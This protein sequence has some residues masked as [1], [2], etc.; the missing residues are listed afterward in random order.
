VSKSNEFFSFGA[1]ETALVTGGT[2]GIGKAVVDLLRGQGVRVTALYLDPVVGGEEDKGLRLM[3]CDIRDEAA[4]VAVVKEL[5]ASWGHIDMLVNNAA[6]L[7]RAIHAPFLEHTTELFRNVVE[8]NLIGTFVML[9]EVARAMIDAGT[10]GRIVNVSSARGHLGAE[11]AAGY[12]S[13]KT[14][15]IGLTRSAALALAPHNIRVNAVAPGYI[16]SELAQRESHL[17]PDERF[18]KAI[19]LGRTGSPLDAARVIAA[20]LSAD[21]SFVTGSTWDVDGGIRAY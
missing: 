10:P 11:C 4:I 13:A 6:I 12:G 15:V 3:R 8:T 17:P 7:G 21:S 19:P 20:L 5:I 14:G 18:T 2:T 16:M 1:D 9:R